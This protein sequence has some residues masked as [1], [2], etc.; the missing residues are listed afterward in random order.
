MKSF[1]LT[2]DER[3]L[4]RTDFIRK[5]FKVKKRTFPHFS[6][7][8]K[9]NSLGRTRLGLAVGKNTGKAVQRNRIKRLLREFFRRS[10]DKFPPSR[11]IIIVVLKG[12]DPLTYRQVF[13]ELTPLLV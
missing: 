12:S 4:K 9:P 2:K 1:S 10:K 3:I 13:E 6:V 7:I 5:S 11:D 8:I